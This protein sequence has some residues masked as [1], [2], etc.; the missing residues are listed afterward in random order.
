MTE[1]EI[2]RPPR[3]K[4]IIKLPFKEHPVNKIDRQ[5]EDLFFPEWLATVKI[6]PRM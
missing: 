5:R 3:K 4:V 2:I 1:I 6:E